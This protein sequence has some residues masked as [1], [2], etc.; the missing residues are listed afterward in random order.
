[1]LLCYFKPFDSRG[2]RR[3]GKKSK[4]ALLLGY[5]RETGTGQQ[6]T[7]LHDR[8]M[9]MIRIRGKFTRMILVLFQKTSALDCKAFAT[10]KEA[11]ATVFIMHKVFFI[12]PSC[13]WTICSLIQS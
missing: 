6:V 11:P 1:M 2:K 3:L 4:L 9:M 7:Q 8:Y 13:Q 5:A 12:L 10:K